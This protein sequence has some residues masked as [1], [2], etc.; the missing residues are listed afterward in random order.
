MKWSVGGFR[1]RAAIGEEGDS[2]EEWR[3]GSEILRYMA[4]F[5][6]KNHRMENFTC[7]NHILREELLCLLNSFKQ[8]INVCSFL[9]THFFIRSIALIM[10]VV[11]F[12]LGCAIIELTRKVWRLIEI[13]QKIYK[14]DD[15]EHSVFNCVF[16]S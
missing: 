15:N 8:Q 1:R 11:V 4:F 16:A 12:F 9:S 7:N 2:F 14:W 5:D 10:I 3:M 6:L 13:K